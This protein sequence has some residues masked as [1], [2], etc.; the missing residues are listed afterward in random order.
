MNRLCE[1]SKERNLKQI[2]TVKMINMSQTIT[3]FYNLFKLFLIY[4]YSAYF[5]KAHAICALLA[6][7]RSCNC[8]MRRLNLFK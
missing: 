8:V 7:F 3:F 1:L 2:E 4:Y 6:S 5:S